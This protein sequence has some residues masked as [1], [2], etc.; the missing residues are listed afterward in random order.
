MK[1]PE[2]LA[3]ISKV[4]NIIDSCINANQLHTCERLAE[5]YTKLVKEKG[6]VN[7][8]LVKHV[9]DIKIKEK[10]EELQ[11]IDTFA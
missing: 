7:F 9:L 2:E 3:P 8:G 10:A 11:Y 1:K 6:V 5:A 4:F